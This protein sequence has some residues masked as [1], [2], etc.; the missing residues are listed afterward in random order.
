[1]LGIVLLQ[2]DLH[3]P[4]IGEPQFAGGFVAH[5]GQA[6][7]VVLVARVEGLELER[8]IGVRVRV[9]VVSLGVGLERLVETL[10]LVALEDNGG[11]FDDTAL[12][13]D[14][15]ADTFTV[16]LAVEF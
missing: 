13:V 10:R 5:L 11:Q 16:Q 14:Q 7:P 12:A 1:M 8:A 6:V 15:E 9:L 2:A 3:I 4:K